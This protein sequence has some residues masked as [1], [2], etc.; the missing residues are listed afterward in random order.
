MIDTTQMHQVLVN[1]CTNAW[2]SLQGSTG[3]IQV[4]LEL[5][6]L[7]ANEAVRIGTMTP[8]PHAH[9]WV[10]DNGCGMDPATKAR[11]FEPFFTTKP[12][13]EGTGLGLSVVHGIV[14]AHQGAITVDSSPGKGSAFHLYFPAQTKV[15]DGASPQESEAPFAALGRGERVF[16]IDDDEVMGLMVGRL[17]ERCGFRPTCHQV[18]SVALAAIQAQPDICDL[19]VTDFNMPEVSG[20]DVACA[21][22]A[23]RPDLPVIISSG[24]IPDELRT[25]AAECGV[26]AILAKENTFEDLAALIVQV[27]GSAD[28]TRTMSRA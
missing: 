12:V 6:Q 17:L 7:D 25:S 21:L 19:V 15:D 13:G 9:I 1:L 27:L 8:G 4:G 22:S 16:Y 11:I 20:I 24:Y 23:V 5:L 10:I 26:K 14:A 28:P 2:H 18:A 3:Q